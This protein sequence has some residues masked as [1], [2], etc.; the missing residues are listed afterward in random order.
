M[1]GF[2]MKLISRKKKKKKKRKGKEKEKEREI[3]RKTL[4]ARDLY[5]ERSQRE[6]HFS[7]CY[8]SG[9]ASTCMRTKSI[10]LLIYVPVN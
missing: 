5:S 7:I 6:Q 9:F 2:E 10:C 3:D 4:G 8:K 1:V